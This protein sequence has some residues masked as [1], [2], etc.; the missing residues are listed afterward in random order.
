MLVWQTIAV[1]SIQA[2]QRKL[3]K[4]EYNCVVLD[5]DRNA[6]LNIERQAL[7]IVRGRSGFTDS[8][9]AQGQDVRPGARQSWMNCENM[10]EE[11]RP[12]EPCQVGTV[13]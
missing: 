10:A 7:N 8:L 12:S 9:N 3:D 11:R 1:Y 5:R 4:G 6:A 2:A 13:W